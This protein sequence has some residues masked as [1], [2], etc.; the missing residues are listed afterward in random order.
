MPRNRV[1]GDGSLTQ[2]A[3]QSLGAH[4]RYRSRA[5]SLGQHAAVVTKVEDAHDDL[6]IAVARI[7]PPLAPAGA[8]DPSAT[9]AAAAS[10]RA[11][12]GPRSAA[13][14]KAHAVRA[15]GGAPVAAPD[16]DRH[17]RDLST[18]YRAEVDRS[19]PMSRRDKRQVRGRADA[20][21][22]AN[23]AGVHHLRLASLNADDPR[24]RVL[25]ATGLQH[26]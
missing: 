2:R 24:F 7:R 18:W 8:P 12:Y 19:V 5:H 14:W 10:L 13:V 26:P 9:R 23:L 15:L 3:R 6:C 20:V 21:L 25:S 16:L 11:Q 1:H 4:K 22:A 17:L